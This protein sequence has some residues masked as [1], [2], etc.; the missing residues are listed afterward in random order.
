MNEI[1]SS[2]TIECDISPEIDLNMIDLK[3]ID[4][5]SRILLST[6]GTLTKMLEAIF[7]EKIEI[8]KILNNSFVKD[9]DDLVCET[10]ENESISARE[11]LLKGAKTNRNYVF[12][13]TLILNERL[14][15]LFYNELSETDISIGL[16]WE[17][18]RVELYK[19]F[20][21]YEVVPVGNLAP[22]FNMQSNDKI[23]SRTYLVYIKGQPVAQITEKFS[24][25]RMDMI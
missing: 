11:V 13:K 1:N 19:K 3:T 9:Y 16:L 7:M 18:H 20:Y 6:N 8:K 23:Y 22:Y 15:D 10:R 17:K 2:G 4:P 5:I 14:S 24:D 25:F 21:D 12:A